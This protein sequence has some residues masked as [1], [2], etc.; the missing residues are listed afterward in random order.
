[1]FGTDISP[2]QNLC[3][4]LL[5]VA[6]DETLIPKISYSTYLNILTANLRERYNIAKKHQDNYLSSRSSSVNVN[7]K[8]DLDDL[9]LRIFPKRSDKLHGHEGPF[10]I[11]NILGNN[12][13]EISSLCNEGSYVCSGNH[14]IPFTA[15]V[16]ERE[17]REIA[18]SD[19]SEFVVEDIKSHCYINEELQFQILWS[20]GVESWETV[21][22]LLL[23][24]KFQSYVRQHR[25][26]SV[27]KR[28][29]LKPHPLEKKE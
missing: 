4:V 3:D 29:K 12:S 8:S 25:L 27:V 22:Y 15:K 14:L 6:E 26:K 16:S 20:K 24:P 28:A 9:V 11:S 5:E 1:M 19:F 10:K 17:A 18:A 7:P 23:N 13:Y 2:R 21:H